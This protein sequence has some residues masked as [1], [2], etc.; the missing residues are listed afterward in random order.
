[1]LVEGI[2]ADSPLVIIVV[3]VWMGQGRFRLMLEI[4]GSRGEE[5]SLQ[6]TEEVEG[7][8]F[9]CRRLRESRGKGEGDELSTSTLA[10]G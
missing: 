7:E 3:R 5:G 8:G 6:P 1:M 10:C 9:I 2:S 4:L